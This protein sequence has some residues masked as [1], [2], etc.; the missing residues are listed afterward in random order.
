MSLKSFKNLGKSLVV[1]FVPKGGP[2]IAGV[3]KT[4]KIAPGKIGKAS[5]S[6]SSDLWVK[7]GVLEEIKS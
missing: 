6:P 3:G 1:L 7:A 5:R 2:D 4:V